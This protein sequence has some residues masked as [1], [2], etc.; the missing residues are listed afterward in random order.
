MGNV[1]TKMSKRAQIGHAIYIMISSCGMG[2]KY[3]FSLLHNGK[4]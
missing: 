4:C 3:I 2:M 1:V